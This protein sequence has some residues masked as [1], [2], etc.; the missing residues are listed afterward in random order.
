MSLLLM[1]SDT[2]SNGWLPVVGIGQSITLPR[3]ADRP[4]GTGSTQ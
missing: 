1:V 4:C 2:I 3:A